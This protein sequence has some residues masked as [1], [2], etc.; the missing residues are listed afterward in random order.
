ML[1]ANPYTDGWMIKIQASDVSELEALMDGEQYSEG[2][3]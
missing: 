1:N 3:E 2:L